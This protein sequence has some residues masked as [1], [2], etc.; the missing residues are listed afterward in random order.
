MKILLWFALVAAIVAA[1]CSALTRVTYIGVLSEGKD[2]AGVFGTPG[3]L[4]GKS[5]TFSMTFDYSLG[6]TL[7]NGSGTLYGTNPTTLET[8]GRS[9][10][11]TV[12]GTSYTI[13]GAH[14]EGYT[15]IKHGGSIY[16]DGFEH[17][18]DSFNCPVE[19][20]FSNNNYAE[21]YIRAN[22]SSRSPGFLSSSDPR[23]SVS[24]VP[25]IGDSAFG[26]FHIARLDPEIFNNVELAYGAFRPTSV[27]ISSVPDAPTWSLILVGF[28]LIGAVCRAEIKTEG[29]ERAAPHLR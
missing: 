28:G 22:V 12:G 16:P 8:P 25:V 1:P 4:I 26:E 20:C 13:A 27:V 19:G 14:V 2:I 24:Y 21:S 29:L 18:F 3:S 23:Q 10:V 5:V 7:P 15:F 17:M 11:V 6:R 9:G